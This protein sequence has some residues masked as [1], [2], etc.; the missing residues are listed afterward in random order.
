MTYVHIN[1]PKAVKRSIHSGHCPDC[2]RNSRFI[3]LFYEWYGWDTTCLRCG[4]RWSDGEWMPLPFYQHARRDSI[5][6]AKSHWRRGV[7]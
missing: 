7:A 4:R 6:S 1:A 3:G 2:K 5:A